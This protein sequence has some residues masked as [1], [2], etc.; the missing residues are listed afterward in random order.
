MTDVVQNIFR[1]ATTLPKE[2]QDYVL[3][4]VRFLQFQELAKQYDI[5]PDKLLHLHTEEI[6]KQNHK[7]FQ[8]ALEHI[9]N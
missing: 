2:Y 1:E 9:V 5:D 6:A 7:D 4:F 8:K 3:T